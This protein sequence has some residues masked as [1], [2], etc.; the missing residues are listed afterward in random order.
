MSEEGRGDKTERQ[1]EYGVLTMERLEEE[2]LTVTRKLE[3]THGIKIPSPGT[4]LEGAL[5]IKWEASMLIVPVAPLIPM[6]PHLLDSKAH[7]FFMR[8]WF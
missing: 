4:A 5:L 2:W 3:R 8:S 7:S 1:K 6:L